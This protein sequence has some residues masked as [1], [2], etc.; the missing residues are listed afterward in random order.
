MLK[1]LMPVVPGSRF[2]R[3]CRVCEKQCVI[4]AVVAKMLVKRCE[5]RCGAGYQKD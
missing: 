2:L 3:P 5:N 1:S 4:V